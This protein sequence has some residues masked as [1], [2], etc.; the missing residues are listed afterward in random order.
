[1]QKCD[2]CN[3]PIRKS[4]GVYVC[5][6]GHMA[7]QVTETADHGFRM[8]HRSITTKSSQ[9]PAPKKPKKEIK[10]IP[11][12]AY[13]YVARGFCDELDAFLIKD[14]SKKMSKK[15]LDYYLY[16]LSYL[17]TQQKFDE[18]M[19]M[20]IMK[21]CIFFKMKE[22]SENGHMDISSFKFPTK[23]QD[24][25][26]R[27][28][29]LFKNDTKL[30]SEH[31]KA[32]KRVE[33]YEKYTSKN[34]PLLLEDF[35]EFYTKDKAVN[36]FQ[37]YEKDNNSSILGVFD[38]KYLRMSG[39]IGSLELRSVI[40][41]FLD[42]D[43]K[44]PNKISNE[45]ASKA[46]DRLT[47]GY[48]LL[49]RPLFK[50]EAMN[51]I[52]PEDIKDFTAYK[53]AASPGVK[54]DVRLPIFIKSAYMS[55]YTAY[56]LTYPA[57][58]AYEEVVLLFLYFYHIVFKITID[59]E[60]LE[61]SYLKF[62]DALTVINTKELLAKERRD[63]AKTL[64]KY[65]KNE[66]IVNSIKI[67]KYLKIPNLKA[68]GLSPKSAFPTL[69]KIFVHMFTRQDDEGRIEFYETLDLLKK[70][71]FQTDHDHS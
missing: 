8:I 37:M 1:M 67:F 42:H 28:P 53:G 9:R 21:C 18:N 45:F 12:D 48:S 2:I 19:C 27:G 13:I 63:A 57:L 16:A 5:T 23:N 11:L 56:L 64:M 49:S 15:D 33:E 68:T 6:R 31:A 58:I 4:D 32:F 35:E 25:L 61:Y 65:T 17:L 7:G 50:I 36:K 71:D 41:I 46:F 55:F 52:K 51:R 47:V 54:I 40:Q 29:R 39:K 3:S 34:F 26:K 44:L 38:M 43:L 30:D 24:S 62:S 10:E 22:L 66:R 14:P 70:L 60:N 69:A 20:C 59:F